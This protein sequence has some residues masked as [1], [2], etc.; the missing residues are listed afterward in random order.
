MFLL[1]FSLNYVFFGQVTFDFIIIDSF[2]LK[3]NNYYHLFKLVKLV[4]EN[5]CYYTKLKKVK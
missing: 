1:A 3:V 4:F 2:L 5:S